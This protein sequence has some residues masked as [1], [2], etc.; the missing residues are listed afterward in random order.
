[1]LF[2]CLCRFVAFTGCQSG[3]TGPNQTRARVCSEKLCPHL[4]RIN[5]RRAAHG[6]M[7]NL[8]THCS[9][10][11]FGVENISACMQN[12]GV[13]DLTELLWVRSQISRTRQSGLAARHLLGYQTKAKAIGLWGESP[14]AMGPRPETDLS[15]RP[16]NFVCTCCPKMG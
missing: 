9:L 3:K 10:Q 15:L 14:R 16:S 2:K 6:I 13:K 8:S 7:F 1:M 4:L 12:G 11:A 5:G